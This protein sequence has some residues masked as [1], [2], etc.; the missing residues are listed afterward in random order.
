VSLQ[1]ELDYVEAYLALEKARFDERLQIQ[2][3]I[4]QTQG[5]NQPTSILDHPVPTLILQPIVENAIVHGIAP[6]TEGGKVSISIEKENDI[7][8]LRVKDNGPGIDARWLAELLDPEGGNN[9]TIG[10]RNVD[11]RLRTLYGEEHRL[12][13]QS[14][15]GQGTMVQIR[16]PIGDERPETK[17]D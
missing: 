12:I 14:E 8:S 11:R 2:W 1:D 3:S 10:L 15:I 13:V 17:D 4:Q 6:K 9:G 5:A 7:L 16:I